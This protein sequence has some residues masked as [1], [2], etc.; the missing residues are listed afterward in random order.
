MPTTRPPTGWANS[1]GRAYQV[2]AKRS[3]FYQMELDI[4]LRQ[5][6][7]ALS[8]ARSSLENVQ[9]VPNFSPKIAEAQVYINDHYTEHLTLSSG[10]KPSEFK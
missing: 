1:S 6:L 7:L 9:H 5:V 8:Q 2:Y 3:P 10:G 4:L